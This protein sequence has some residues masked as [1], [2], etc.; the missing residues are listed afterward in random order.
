MRQRG[1]MAICTS[2][3]VF[4]QLPEAVDVISL[5]GV[6]EYFLDPVMA[7]TNIYA[8]LKPNGVLLLTSLE[9]DDALWSAILETAGFKWMSSNS[10]R[11][12]IGL[13]VIK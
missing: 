9:P 6:F 7:L 11:A 3:D 5:T 13:K 10:Q 2:S 8:S 12:I 1:Y 4:D